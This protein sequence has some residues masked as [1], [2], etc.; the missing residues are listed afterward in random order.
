[1]K[2]YVAATDLAQPLLPILLARVRVLRD[3]GHVLV[4]LRRRMEHL[5][6]ES[7][8]RKSVCI[9][10]SSEFESQKKMSLFV[11]AKRMENFGVF[12]NPFCFS[13]FADRKELRS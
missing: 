2:K 8:F 1:M 5:D 4:I 7:T 12:V 13:K 9:C 10:K 3:E 6:G 11:H